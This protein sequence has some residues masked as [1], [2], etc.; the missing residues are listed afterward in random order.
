MQVVLSERA[1]NRLHTLSR[2]D[3]TKVQVWLE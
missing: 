2:D 1:N 3:R